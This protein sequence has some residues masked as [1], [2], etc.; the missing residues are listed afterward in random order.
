M[1]KPRRFLSHECILKPKLLLLL[2]REPAPCRRAVPKALGAPPLAAWQT[3]LDQLPAVFRDML[4][5]KRPK[6]P[7]Q[8]VG[9]TLTA[10]LWLT[11]CAPGSL[12]HPR[13]CCPPETR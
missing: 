4:G 6:G 2:P 1:Q 9:L 5:W 12:L 11:L 3:H 7:T 13:A 8:R 10:V